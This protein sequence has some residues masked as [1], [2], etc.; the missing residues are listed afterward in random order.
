MARSYAKNV[1]AARMQWAID[2]ILPSFRTGIHMALGATHYVFIK[3]IPLGS[4]YVMETRAGGWD[5][6]WS[7]QSLIYCFAD[8]LPGSIS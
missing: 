4:E 1:D 7:V 5:E 2:V 6:K 8:E 3:E